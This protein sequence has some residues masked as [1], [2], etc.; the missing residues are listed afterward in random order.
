MYFKYTK[1]NKNKDAGS[2]FNPSRLICSKSRKK[3]KKRPQNKEKK[4]ILYEIKLGARLTTL[5]NYAL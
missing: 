1:K 3:S 2:Y 4:L 5:I